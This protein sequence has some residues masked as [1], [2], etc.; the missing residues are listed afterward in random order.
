MRATRNYFDSEESYY[1]LRTGGVVRM[2]ACFGG[3]LKN[4]RD[5]SKIRDRVDLMDLMDLV[6]LV[7]K[8]APASVENYV[9]ACDWSLRFLRGS[10]FAVNS[11]L[12]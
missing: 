12:K 4:F 5:T 8:C 7:W 2:S 3:K 9:R 10:K 11:N 1:F 6:Q